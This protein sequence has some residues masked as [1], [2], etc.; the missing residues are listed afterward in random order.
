MRRLL[1]RTGWVGYRRALAGLLALVV[2]GS[3]V[4][5]A[6]EQASTRADEFANG[7]PN[8]PSFFPIGVWLQQP[9]NAA[10]F[11]AIGINTYVAFWRAPSE[12]DLAHLERHGLYVIAEQTP[13]ILSHRNAHV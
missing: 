4:G 10:A 9:R 8:D 6:A 12:A 13:E 5:L 11:R 1:E 2:A 7:F 3:P